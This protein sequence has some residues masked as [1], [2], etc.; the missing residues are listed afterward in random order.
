MIFCLYAIN[1]LPRKYVGISDILTFHSAFRDL[2]GGA[3]SIFSKIITTMTRKKYH[4]VPF[5]DLWAVKEEHITEPESVHRTKEEAVT[6]AITLAKQTQPSQVFVH[7]KDGKIQEEY[8][9]GNDPHES[10]G[11]L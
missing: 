2:V 9:Y 11:K 8:T 1:N 6:A 3:G 4:V 5:A 10:P 7:G